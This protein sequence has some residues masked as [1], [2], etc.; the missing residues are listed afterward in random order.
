MNRRGFLQSLIAVP[1]ATCVAP[2]PTLASGLVV[3]SGALALD[4]FVAPIGTPFPSVGECVGAPW[5]A[6]N[7]GPNSRLD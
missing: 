1:L 7:L 4:V 5:S 6:V 2:A 3:T